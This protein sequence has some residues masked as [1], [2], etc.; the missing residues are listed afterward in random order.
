MGCDGGTIPTRDELVKLK[1]KPEQ[2]D[3]DSARLYRW[4][5]CTISQ[6]PLKKPIVACEMGRLYNKESVIELLL[7]KDR[8]RNGRTE[9]IDKLKDVVELVLTDNPAYEGTRASVGDGMYVDRLVSPWICPVTGLEMN[10][11]F[12]FMFPWKLGKVVSDRAVK[13][14]QKDEA[15]A[16]KFKEEDIIILNPEED[17]LD[18]MHSKMIARRARIKAGKKAAKESKKK[19]TAENVFKVPEAVAGTSWHQPQPIVGTTVAN[20]EPV[21]STNGDP[22]AG[23]STSGITNGE[24]AAKKQK[25]ANSN[26]FL[27]QK[28]PSSGSKKVSSVQEDPGKSEIYK[29]LFSSHKSAQNKPTG[30]W[31]TFDPR[32][33]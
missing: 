5:H 16:D 20:D 11:R 7:S 13:I 22:V 24:S 19:R 10:G 15:E 33:N 6:E 12:K 23:G 29:S 18:L 8:E 27:D 32:Y 4:Q 25:K 1:K 3:K 2:R 28:G 14:L 17:D 9:H 21:A 30:H 31:I 26:T